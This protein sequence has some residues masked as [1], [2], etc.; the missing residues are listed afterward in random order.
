MLKY[1]RTRQIQGMLKPRKS[2][3]YLQV[4]SSYPQVPTNTQTETPAGNTCLHYH[5]C[6]QL[7]SSGDIDQSI[8]GASS[9]EEGD[10]S[11][12]LPTERSTGYG[13]TVRGDLCLPDTGAVSIPTRAA[14]PHTNHCDTISTAKGAPSLLVCGEREYS[15]CGNIGASDQRENISHIA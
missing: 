11:H 9:I 7:G 13:T 4:P 8:V 3:N 10:E 1:Q 6:Q 5:D 14:S 12:T 15:S 2:R